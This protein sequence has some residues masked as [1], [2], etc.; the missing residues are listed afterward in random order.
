MLRRPAIFTA[1]L[2]VGWLAY[3][4]WCDLAGERKLE[5]G[6]LAGVTAPVSV[7]IT[8][9]FAPEEF[10]MTRLQQAGRLLGVEGR[11]VRL[12][13]VSRGAATALAR[14]YWVRAIRRDDGG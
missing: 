7:D 5:A 1:L 6:G 2:L 9:A 11:T 3:T 4:A 13:D 8:L 12:G 14:E 10:H